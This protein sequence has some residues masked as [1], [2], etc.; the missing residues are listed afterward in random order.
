MMTTYIIAAVILLGLCI[1]VHELGHLLGG[2][3]VGIK[4]RTFSLGYGKGIVKKK[5]GDTTYQI[6]MFPLGGFCAF[7]GEDP[8]EERTGEGFEF[9]S[10]HPLKRIFTV[11]MGPVFN[12]IFGMLIF[13]VMSLVGY[14]KDTNVVRIPEAW[15][16]GEH[17]SAAY[18]AGVRTGDRIVAIDGESVASFQD[19]QMKVV[20]SEGKKL[21][22]AV[23]R[24]GERRDFN[25][26][27]VSAGGGRYEIGVTANGSR[28]HI[29]DFIDGSP[30][31]AQGLRVR[32]QIVSLDGTVVRDENEFVAF[33]SAR[34]DKVI[35]FKI[36]RNKK[37]MTIP[38][39]P[40]RTE[41]IILSKGNDASGD[42]RFYRTTDL[43]RMIAKGR[44]TLDGKKAASFDALKKDIESLNGAEAV[45]ALGGQKTTARA[46]V[47]E[48]GFLGVRH[49]IA[50]DRVPVQYGLG[51]A[52]VQSVREPYQ[53]VMLNIK[54][55][56]MLFAGKLD[57][58]ENLSGPI[59]IG[60]IAGD[61]YYYKGFAEFVLLMAKISIILMVMNL[62]PIPAVD[63][64]H[65][66]FYLVEL[67]RGK[68]LSQKIMERIQTAG[69]VILIV[70]GA[71]ILVN[72]ISMLPVI[73]RLFD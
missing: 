55:L 66:L 42:Y 24:E 71:F 40:K 8:S 17:V 70:L 57:V 37:E 25:V 51:G 64:S 29:A 41:V 20:F 48:A 4:A 43:E 65:I 12:L 36:L 5:F 6:G 19:I 39:K 50:P 44:V 34:P 2:K 58:R 10:A 68:P 9:L 35:S 18:A 38:V 22:L 46:R 13:F 3:A 7:Y 11:A 30:A 33:V 72:D 28:L 56:G 60:K 53:F 14:T 54:G 67:V 47:E 31:M 23:D 1:F 61:V 27:P 16:K 15:Q 21:K 52:L 26:T 62:L 73:Q 63:G 59:R 49:E 69:V 32:D 45:F